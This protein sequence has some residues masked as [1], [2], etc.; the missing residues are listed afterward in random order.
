MPERAHVGGFLRIFARR[1]RMW[2]IPCDDHRSY[3]EM[4]KYG[5]FINIRQAKRDVP[6]EKKGAFRAFSVRGAFLRRA[7]RND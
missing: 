7:R 4:E 5:R 1:A 3:L 6:F 2:G